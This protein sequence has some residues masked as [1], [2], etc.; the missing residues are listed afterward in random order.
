MTHLKHM[1]QT[2]IKIYSQHNVKKDQ[3]RSKKVNCQKK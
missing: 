2:N 1:L 3:G